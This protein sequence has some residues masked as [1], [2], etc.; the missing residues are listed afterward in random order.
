MDHVRM[1]G[2]AH[3]LD[4]RFPVR[5]RDRR[6]VHVDRRAR[7]RMLVRHVRWIA[8]ETASSVRRYR[9]EWMFRWPR[10][11]AF[12][13]EKDAVVLLLGRLFRVQKHGREDRG[14]RGIIRRNKF[15]VS[16]VAIDFRHVKFVF[17][18][19]GRIL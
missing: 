2:D 14:C 5:L 17:V 3:T 19:H 12:D 16:V 11:V 7:I 9:R 10:S 4:H 18:G 8:L 13:R 15:I 6:V 1:D